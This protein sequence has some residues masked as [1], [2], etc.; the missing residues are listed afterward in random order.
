M[1]GLGWNIAD[2]FVDNGADRFVN[3]FIPGNGMF[4]FSSIS[5]DFPGLLRCFANRC[6]SMAQQ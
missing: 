4:A 6:R 1:A 2:A 5:Y 3:N